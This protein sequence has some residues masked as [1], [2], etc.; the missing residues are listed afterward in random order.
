MDRFQ[1]RVEKMM[2][3]YVG[4]KLSKFPAIIPF[5]L[6]FDLT[7]KLI[8][9]TDPFLTE[10]PTRWTNGTILEGKKMGGRTSSIFLI[11]DKNDVVLYSAEN[12]TESIGAFICS[13]EQTIREK[14][15]GYVGFIAST[16]W[17]A[18]STKE[19]VLHTEKSASD[20]ISKTV[21]AQICALAE[22]Q[23]DSSP[24][25]ILM[26]LVI[27]YDTFRFFSEPFRKAFIELGNEMAVQIKDAW[28][29]R[30]NY[31]EISSENYGSISI[32]QASWENGTT[33]LVLKNSKG[34]VT[35][36]WSTYAKNPGIQSFHSSSRNA[37]RILKDALDA[38]ETTAEIKRMS[39]AL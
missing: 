37:K 16:T 30:S 33:F 2:W 27:S 11:V 28:Q 1:I 35:L 32:E 8:D 38:L 7:V 23:K 29:Q 13:L 21:D 10:I 31:K 24:E 5:I 6:P 3:K 15:F 14:K 19:L 18:N 4:E 12:T 9:L 20:I 39:I 25:D 26:D 17:Y 36:I 22:T 34:Q